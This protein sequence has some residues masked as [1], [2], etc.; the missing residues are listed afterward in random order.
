MKVFKLFC[1]YLVL[2]LVLAGGCASKQYS[3]KN[4]TLTGLS[5]DQSYIRSEIVNSMPEK[6]WNQKGSKY[7][8]KET[9][10]G[11]L[12]MASKEDHKKIGKIV[13]DILNKRLKGKDVKTEKMGDTEFIIQWDK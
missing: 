8:I 5:V 10:H 7:A 6:N 3:V 13:A 11:L 1:F 4:Y 2:L 12:V 9:K